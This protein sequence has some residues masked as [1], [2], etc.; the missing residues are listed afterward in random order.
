MNVHLDT[1]NIPSYVQDIARILHKEGFAAYLVGGSVRDLIM[2]RAPHDYDIGTD[3]LPEDIQK[4]FPKAIATGAKFGA[5]IVLVKDEN[6]E[7]QP[8]DVTTFR[9]EEQYI[10]G[11]W[12]SKVEFTRNIDDDL[13]RRDFTINAMALDLARLDQEDGA[14]ILL[15]P[16]GGQDDIKRKLIRAV[17]DAKQRLKEDALRALR[18]CR[19]ASVLGFSVDSGIIEATS[20]IL[21]M[22]DNLSAERVRDEFQ[23]II[24]NSPRPSIGIRLLQKTGI[25]GVWIP[26]L[27]EGVGV[28]QPEYHKYDVYEHSLRTLDKADDKGKLAALFHDIGKPRTHKDGHFYRHDI[29]GAEMTKE[30]LKRLRFS[31]KEIDQ[32]CTLV[33]WHMFYFPYDEDSLMKG[34][35]RTERSQPGVGEW[36]DAAIRRFVKNVGGEDAIDDL[37]RLRIADATANPMSSFN[38]KEICALQERIAQVRQKDMALKVSDLDIK[39]EDLEALG[40]DPG[41]KMGKILY[42]LLELVIED[43]AINDKEKLIN[44]V[45]ENYLKDEN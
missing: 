7:S 28:E 23:K 20:E 34:E 35:L 18:A 9:T 37:I 30:I 29:V 21:P 13:S 32:V 16:F 10:G 41:P 12:P 19:L 24:Y 3:A 17:G 2:K 43:P 31:N 39:G 15:D 25:L 11:R 27:L 42:E 1:T 6:N 36:G 40:I 45:K 14:A 8:V 26:E 22:I 4:I 38:E 44:I 5:M 33:R